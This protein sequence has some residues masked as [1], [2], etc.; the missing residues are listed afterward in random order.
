MF[1]VF[2]EYIKGRI[3]WTDWGDAYKISVRKP[4]RNV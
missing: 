1:S 2:S 3:K 4:E